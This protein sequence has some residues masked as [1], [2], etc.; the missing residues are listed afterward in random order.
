MVKEH[1][2]KIPARKE[3]THK[4]DFGHVFVVAGSRGMTGA[5]YL[6][7]QAA[8]LSGSG[9]VTCGIPESLN[10][11]MEVKL[12]EAMTLALPGTKEG[13]LAQTA[14][15]EII[16]F[17]EKTDVI[18]LGPGLSR[19][20]ET[21]KLVLNLLK[22][23]QKPIVLDAD[24]VIALIGNC[25]MLKKRKAPTILTP[26][27]GE[28]SKLIAKDIGAIRRN[29]E[30]IA[31]G[32]AKKYG[33]ILVLKGHGTVVADSKSSAYT[34][35]TG[36]SGMSTAGAGDVLTGMVASFVG[37]GINPYS[38]AVIGVYLHGLAGDIA[39][40]EKGQFSMMAGDLLEKLPQAIQEAL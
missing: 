26:H 4:G 6:A 22:G 19:H 30:K 20:R 2:S 35:R 38:A 17:A 5:A 23:I 9:L 12:T 37:Q 36:N 24:G 21:Q 32:F 15:K 3:D 16:N 1:I 33:V 25:D 34:N 40:R 10:A 39:A 28:M 14:E 18:A 7:S 11:V 29:R 8:L 13:S 31:L 27:P